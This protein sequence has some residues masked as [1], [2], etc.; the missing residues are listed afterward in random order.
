MN[1]SFCVWIYSFLYFPALF[2]CFYDF[3]QHCPDRILILCSKEVAIYLRFFHPWQ[4][5]FEWAGLASGWTATFLPFV[6]PVKSNI[7]APAQCPIIIFPLSPNVFNDLH[8]IYII[9]LIGILLKYR[10]CIATREN[11]CVKLIFVSLQISN[12][13]IHC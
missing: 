1:N 11:E 3:R 9:R 6:I 13:I 12:H 7:I 8:Q 10:H 4:F 5:R 2:Q